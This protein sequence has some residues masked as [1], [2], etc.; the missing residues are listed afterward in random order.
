[1]RR[2]EEPFGCDYC[3]VEIGA[4]HCLLVGKGLGQVND[5]KSGALPEAD[6]QAKAALCKK[7]RPVQ[8]FLFHYSVFPPTV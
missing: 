8:W 7:F 5:K 1:M 4:E 3:F 2:L 6:A